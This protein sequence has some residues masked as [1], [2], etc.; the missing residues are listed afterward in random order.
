MLYQASFKSKQHP[1]SPRGYHSL[2]LTLHQSISKKNS[3]GEPNSVHFPPV[4]YITYRPMFKNE[5]EKL[6][7]GAD[8]SNIY[9]HE[10]T[11]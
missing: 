4:G 7:T 6:V 9:T 1:Y 10:K 3:K 2:F 11:D 8:R 5:K